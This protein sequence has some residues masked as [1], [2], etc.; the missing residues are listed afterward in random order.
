MIYYKRILSWIIYKLTTPI[1][2]VYYLRWKSKDQFEF[3]FELYEFEKGYHWEKASP[4][5]LLV[6]TGMSLEDCLTAYIKMDVARR[7]MDI[8]RHNNE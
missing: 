7:Y 1:G 3:A 8:V 4:L 2:D 5:H 6:T